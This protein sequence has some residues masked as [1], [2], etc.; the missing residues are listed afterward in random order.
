MTAKKPT[1][2]VLLEGNTQE[3]KIRD[4][5]PLTLPLEV[6]EPPEDL[7]PAAGAIWKAVGTAMAAAGIIG[8]TDQQAF[9]RYCQI[10]GMYTEAME[11][12]KKK[13]KYYPVEKVVYEPDGK[14]IWK[15]VMV[16]DEAG[17]MVPKTKV[18][19]L[20][21][22]PQ[23]SEV[24]TWA[25]MLLALERELGL[26]PVARSRIYVDPGYAHRFGATTPDEPDDPY[27]P[28]DGEIY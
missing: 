15:A 19:R 14:G 10:Y 8:L 12:L 16:K 24:Q 5:E 13:G 7:S 25:T 1:G 6:G 20:L 27:E 23:L 3:R 21:P 26:T 2:L 17:R 28:K 9:H 22:F 11:F 18:E 4:T